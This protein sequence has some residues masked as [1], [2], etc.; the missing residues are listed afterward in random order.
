MKW[1]GDL[2]IGTR[3]LLSFLVIL[4]VAVGV[5]IFAVVNMKII[6]TNYEQAML[7]TQ[8][9]TAHIFNAKDY[10][11]DA[12]M[13]IR[14]IFYPENTR[15]DLQRLSAEMNEDIQSL[16]D[17]LNG[18]IAV[19]SPVVQESSRLILQKADDYLRDTQAI[20]DKLLA[21]DVISTDNPDYIKALEIAQES[22]SAIGKSYA[23]EMTLRI[24]EL[25]DMALGVLKT[26]SDS[27]GAQA[28][29][30]LYITIGLCLLMSLLVVA[31]ALLA[32]GSI[33]R[34]LNR[35][36]DVANRV[37]EGDL[38]VQIDTSQKDETGMLAKS[39]AEVVGVVHA[40][41]ESLEAMSK[42]NEAGDI[43]TR[44]ETTR[45]TGAYKKVT[46]SINGLYKGLVDE[47]LGMLTCLSSFGDGDFNANVP[48]KPGKKIIM[49]NVIDNLRN[50]LKSVNRDVNGLVGAAKDGNLSNRVL[51][52]SYKG[53]WASVVQ[54]LNNLMDAI[55]APINEILIVMDQVYNGEFSHTVQG[56]Y[57]GAFLDIKKAV[58][59]TV[60]QIA[61]YIDEIADV[62]SALAHHD[63]NQ[64]IKRDY[65]GKFSDIKVALTDI[66]SQFNE[67]ISGIDSAAGQVSAGARLI[68]ENNMSLATGTTEQAAALEQLNATV[69]MINANTLQNADSAK[70]ANKLSDNAKNNA[71]KGDADM[72]KMLHSM[73]G[74]KD[75]SNKISKII[76]VIEDIAF[77]TN[78]LALNAAVEAARAGEHG[79][80]FAVVADEVRSLAGKTQSSA[81]ETASL[82]EEA[83]ERVN[84]GMET[85][86]E[87]AEALQLIVGESEKVADVVTGISNASD[88]QALAVE[89]MM[90]G[91]SQIT[92]VVQSNSAQTEES[93]S[94]SQ[95]LSG[96][97]DVL[98]QMTGAFQLKNARHN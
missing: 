92:Q 41:I 68:S 96:Q 53:D 19:A 94:A 34:P 37:T 18:L 2:K 43:D 32:A 29:R 63:L 8:K 71:E 35:L 70:Q 20:I 57:K 54:E 80:G 62:L 44:I 3:L 26:L 30:A 66:I 91:L 49:N 93:A 82:I 5:G 85:A 52:D 16:T 98:K 11:A 72:K 81:K 65:V 61:S 46:E 33:R 40:M 89:Q 48:K 59:G 13:T 21:L 4:A 74:I 56:N 39:F 69:E 9:R 60:A 51:A 7:L 38:S 14:E 1:Y 22:T 86:N 77:Q 36:L 64:D 88:E 67:V 23:N 84:D 10:Y 31:I 50:N 73:D 97:S 55:S 58:N 83:I 17:E 90:V 78:L 25:S 6:D 15:E 79:K 47:V 87:T 28:D 76:K 75:S 95:E 45:F 12:R 27:N 24:Q 42:A